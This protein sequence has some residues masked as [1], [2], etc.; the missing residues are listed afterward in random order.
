MS[1]D[2]TIGDSTGS[3]PT[4]NV[5]ELFSISTVTNPSAYP[6]NIQFPDDLQVSHLKQLDGVG[7]LQS[8][9]NDYR[10]G[11]I[12]W[13]CLDLSHYD[14]SIGTM[15]YELK[16]R[17]YTVSGSEYYIGTTVAIVGSHSATFGA[18]AK[19]ITGSGYSIFSVGDKIAVSGTTNNNGV[20]TIVTVS[21][22]VITVS[23]TI[24]DETST[25]TVIG[26]LTAYFLPVNPMKIR[27]IDVI[28]EKIP[29]SLN[30]KLAKVKMAF[31]KVE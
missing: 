15:I 28:T 3:P 20:Y 31:Q 6:S 27:I 7:V 2:L 4:G 9:P 25:T 14:N 17:R 16:Q 1:V 18:V 12:V 30:R 23:E 19:T 22:T 26:K 10:T 8:P 21:S 13:E 24:I 5:V 29:N 11:E